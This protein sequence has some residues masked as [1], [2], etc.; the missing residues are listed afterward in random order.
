LRRRLRAISHEA[1]RWINVKDIV[2]M[3]LPLPVHYGLG[4]FPRRALRGTLVLLV[5]LLSVGPLF[6]GDSLVWEASPGCRKA[7]L[8]EPQGGRTGF[9]EVSAAITGV[10]FQ[11]RLSPIEVFRSQGGGFAKM[12]GATNWQ[13]PDD[14]AGLAGWVWADGRRRS[15]RCQRDAGLEEEM[16][17]LRLRALL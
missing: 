8:M 13:A 1:S 11:N 9:R 16:F 15:G 5:L 7:R 6:S 14:V 12:P 4:S 2:T 3:A 10:H 17:W